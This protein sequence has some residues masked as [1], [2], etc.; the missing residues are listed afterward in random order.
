MRKI[1]QLGHVCM[2]CEFWKS[3]A[4]DG[5][6]EKGYSSASFSEPEEN[7]ITGEYDWCQE[8]NYNPK[9]KRLMETLRTAERNR[10]E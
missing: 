5:K 6:C 7:G 2:Y 3:K 4:I 8:F 10:T 1:A 9:D